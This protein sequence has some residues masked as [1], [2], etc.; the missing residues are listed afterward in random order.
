[1]YSSTGKN[2]TVKERRFEK[3]S[4]GQHFTRFVGHLSEES[5]TSQCSQLL[6]CS[7]TPTDF[8][9]GRQITGNEFIKFRSVLN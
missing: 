2:K 5:T 7:V 1:M 8:Q 4:E 6:T 3:S 9:I